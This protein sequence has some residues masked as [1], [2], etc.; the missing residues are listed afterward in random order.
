MTRLRRLPHVVGL[1]VALAG[2]GIASTA[3]GVAAYGKA[4]QPLAQVEISANCNNPS[5]FFCSQ[6]VGTGGIWL[7]IEVDADG[8]A[9]VRG[10]E[11]G[12]TIGGGGAGAGS[13]RGNATWV[14]S[15]VPVGINVL[16][17]ADPTDT[18]GFTNWYVIF[19]P[20]GPPFSVPVQ[21]GHYSWQPTSGVSLQT[22]VAP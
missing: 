12:H 4:D 10:A 14:Y 15:P 6:V 1:A 11:C 22:T 19:V 20:G 9:D 21:T 5:Y 7:W 17:A 16:D 13:V 18:H 2:L 3:T 8:T